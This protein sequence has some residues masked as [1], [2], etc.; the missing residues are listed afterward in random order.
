MDQAGNA[1]EALSLARKAIADRHDVLTLDVYARALLAN[2]DK[3]EASRQIRKAI[4]VGTKEPQILHDASVIAKMM[5]D[6]TGATR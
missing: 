1:A 3:A 6:R 4:D 5:D 2:G